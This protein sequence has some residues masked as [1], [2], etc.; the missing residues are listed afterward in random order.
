MLYLQKSDYT[1]SSWIQLVEDELNAGRPVQY[2]GSGSTGGHSFVCDGFDYNDYF[3]FNWGWSGAYNGY[4][5]VGNLNPGT[6][7]FSSGQ[8]A[9]VGIQPGSGGTTTE[10]Q[11]YSPITITPDPISFYS[12]FDVNADFTN[13]GT[14]NFDGD[15]CAAIFDE[16]GNFIDYVGM[17]SAQSN[18]LP[19]GYHYVGG[20]TFSNFGM[21]AVPGMYMIGVYYREIGGEWILAGS[22]SYS[23]PVYTI[24][25]SPWNLLEQ[26]SD[27]IVYPTDLVNGQSATVNVNFYN[28]NTYTYYGQYEAALY[29]TDGNYIQSLGTYNETGGLPSGYIYLEPYITF[30]CPTITA[31]PGTYVLAILETEA[32]TTTP[33][34]IGGTY[35]STPINIVVVDP[36]LSPDA[37]EPNNTQSSARTL[38]TQWSNN[39]AEVKT[40]GS[41]IHTDTDYDYYKINLASGYNYNITARAHDSYNSG[42][43]QVYTDDIL[44]SYNAGQGW[45]ESYDDIMSGTIT[46][47][48]S[49]V[50][51]FQV[52][53]YYT[54]QTGTYLLDIQIQRGTHVNIDELKSSTLKLF[55]NPAS[56]IVYITHEDIQGEAEWQIFNG[57]GQKVLTGNFY[58]NAIEIDISGLFEGSYSFVTVINNKKYTKKFI[59]NK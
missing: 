40:N 37:Y 50:V 27:I 56:N 17:M 4:F 14:S 15:Y 21:L 49:G 43:G 1:N 46:V 6:Y 47:I 42:N 59:I 7:N 16:N 45:S 22:S 2:R 48:G 32:G 10:I 26:Y 30:S 3:H 25:N 24:I 52:A 55:P 9:L 34:F 53:S 36:P 35:F 5:S 38:T 33:Y 28:T 11:L 19:P 57:L 39:F 41:N 31:Q 51:Y 58:Q 18:P 13:V 44:W 54:G 12:P 29:D 8:G 23:N 20:L